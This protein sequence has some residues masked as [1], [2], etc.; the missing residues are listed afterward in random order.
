MTPVNYG[1]TTASVSVEKET[2]IAT[3]QPIIIIGEPIIQKI[4]SKLTRTLNSTSST[5][6]TI[7]ISSPKQ[8]ESHYRIHRHIVSIPNLVDN[9]RSIRLLPQSQSRI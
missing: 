3:Q 1:R 6:R 8:T 7:S 9:R 5:K 4:F 2:P